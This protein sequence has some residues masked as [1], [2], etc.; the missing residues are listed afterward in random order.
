MGFVGSWF[1]FG[2]KCDS[3]GGWSGLDLE[4]DCTNEMGEEK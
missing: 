2:G 3:L 1:L 4:A